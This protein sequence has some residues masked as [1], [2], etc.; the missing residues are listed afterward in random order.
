M[1]KAADDTRELKARAFMANLRDEFKP[2]IPRDFIAEVTITECVEKDGAFDMT[3]SVGTI[4]PTGK[5]KTFKY[6]SVVNVDTEGN[7]FLSKLQ[8]SEL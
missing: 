7:P 6:V 2:F 1:S 3:G 4:S 5:E 8:V